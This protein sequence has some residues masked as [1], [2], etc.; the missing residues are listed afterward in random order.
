MAKKSMPM[1][2]KKSSCSKGMNTVRRVVNVQDV[3]DGDAGPAGGPKDNPIL[4]CHFGLKRGRGVVQCVKG[5]LGRGNRRGLDVSVEG[6]EVTRVHVVVEESV[7]LRK[8][9]T[10]PANESRRPEKRTSEG[11]KSPIGLLLGGLR[12]SCRR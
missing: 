7:Q 8:S 6:I 11:H 12:G 5:R 4:E 3:R 1:I 9:S 2:T 10:S